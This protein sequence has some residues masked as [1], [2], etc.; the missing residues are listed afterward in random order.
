MLFTIVTTSYQTTCTVSERSSIKGTHQCKPTCSSFI[1]LRQTPWQGPPNGQRFQDRDLPRQ[2]PPL[3]ETPRQITPRQRPLPWTE[4]PTLDRDLYPG[5]RPLP[6][7][8]TPPPLTE[9]PTLDRDS[10]PWTEA[11]RT[12]TENPP[13]VNRITDRCKNLTL[14]QLRSGR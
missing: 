9:T 14:P 4:T 10:S 8:E 12:W 1:A 3:T 7:T 6:W 5:Q 11:P 13:T 2:K